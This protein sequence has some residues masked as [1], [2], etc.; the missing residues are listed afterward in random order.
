[1]LRL[2]QRLAV[3]PA[4]SEGITRGCRSAALCVIAVA[5]PTR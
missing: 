5:A 4:R 3:A 1:M 2:G